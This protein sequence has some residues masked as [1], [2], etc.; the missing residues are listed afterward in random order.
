MEV[1]GGATTANSRS[2]G[3]H[4]SWDGQDS[5]LWGIPTCGRHAA[6]S[7][8]VGKLLSGDNSLTSVLYM[9]FVDKYT[10]T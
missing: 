4:H 9:D 7:N 8:S 6:I 2:R 5:Q 10:L 1:V 3:T